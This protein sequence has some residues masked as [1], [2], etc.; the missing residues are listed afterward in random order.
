LELYCKVLPFLQY[1]SKGI[2]GETSSEEVRLTSYEKS[3]LDSE[4]T[5]ISCV[6]YNKGLFFNINALTNEQ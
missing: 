4:I 5:H 6:N 2:L 3:I 1:V